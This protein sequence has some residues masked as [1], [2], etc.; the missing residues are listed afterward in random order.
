MAIQKLLTP[1]PTLTWKAIESVTIVIT[2]PVAPVLIT[3]WTAID[4]C[5]PE[6]TDHGNSRN[7]NPHSQI[8]VCLCRNAGPHTCN[9]KSGTDSNE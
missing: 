9:R 6:P 8:G 3:I 1:V 5:V 4:R 7:I 2:T